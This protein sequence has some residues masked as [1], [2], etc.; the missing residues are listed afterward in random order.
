MQWQD[1][2]TVTIL[3]TPGSCNLVRVQ[4]HRGVM[5]EKPEVAELYNKNMLGVDKMDQLATYYFFLR[6]SVKWWRKVK[7]WLLE[8]SVINTY[9]VYTSRLRQLRQQPR[10]HLQFH[11]ELILQLVTH[12]LQLTAPSRHGPH[13][14]LSLERLRPVPH[15]SVESERR[16]DCRVCGIVGRRTTA[17]FCVTCSDR[18]HLHPGRYFRI[19]HTRENF[20]QP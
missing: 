5:K 6:K 12:R 11:R 17:Y 2:R 4:T 18:P 16:R 7:F 20:Q 13:I 1:K 14:Y 8:V 15:L 9:I 10:S 19:Y 3:S